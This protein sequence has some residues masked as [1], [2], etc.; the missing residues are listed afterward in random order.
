MSLDSIAVFLVR[1]PTHPMRAFFRVVRASSLYSHPLPLVSVHL[2]LPFPTLRGWDGLLYVLCSSTAVPMGASRWDGSLPSTQHDTTQPNTTRHDPTQHTAR[3]CGFGMDRMDGREALPH[4]G[5]MENEWKDLDELHDLLEDAL[6][7]PHAPPTGIHEPRHV[8][9]QDVVGQAEYRGHGARD[10][11]KR[12]TGPSREGKGQDGGCPPHPGIIHGVCIRCGKNVQQE[13]E[14]ERWEREKKATRR[15]DKG[16]TKNLQAHEVKLS[17]IKEGFRVSHAE[18]ERIRGLERSRMREAKKLYL[19]LDLDHTL[20]N[21][22]K[23]TEVDQQTRQKLEAYLTD[24]KKRCEEMGDGGKPELFDLRDI[25]IW[26][27]IRPGA[28]EFLE[29]TSKL[30]DLHVYTMGHKLYAAEMAKL[31]DPTRKLFNG[32][33][34]SQQDSSSDA[35]KD[36]DIVLGEPSEVCI[37]DDSPNVWTKH[38]YNV[39]QVGR[40]HFFP[41]SAK[42]FGLDPSS[43][44]LN[45]G[46]DEAVRE[47]EGGQL[48]AVFRT[49]QAT[50]AAIFGT[51]SHTPVPGVQGDIR[52]QLHLL[53]SEILRGVRVLF[54]RIW[55][56]TETHPKLHPL[57]KL[58]ESAGAVCH[59]TVSENI[60]HVVAGGSNTEKV[61]WALKHRK[62]IVTPDWIEKSLQMWTR[63]DERE[64]HFKKPTYK[65]WRGRPLPVES[66]TEGEFVG[67]D[68]QSK[69]P[70][71]IAHPGTH[72]EQ[73]SSAPK[74]AKDEEE[75][76]EI[77]I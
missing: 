6:K 29:Q 76:I 56:E 14:R 61:K 32:H 60:T 43:C 33:I 44:C 46:K 75:I 37:V 41:S 21:S 65:L 49:L 19:V 40:Y 28:Y 51:G 10:V 59:L 71:E 48:A 26:T 52:E 16:C 64:F 62:H 69:D 13:E 2:V 3:A 25:R 12:K 66:S 55:P 8:P 70:R 72:Q 57:W 1:P 74:S 23:Y 38:Q 39:L 20:L 30:F 18:A 5:G 22:T 47:K 77:E 50:H 7:E 42:Q 58:A 31:L 67:K 53:R 15:E 34:I 54:S 73:V 17:Y 45:Y 11:G 36:L 4:E 35:K 63:L 9:I 24:Q 68:L 27:K